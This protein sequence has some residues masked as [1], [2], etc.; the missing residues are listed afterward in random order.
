[1]RHDL[2]AKYY[3]HYY[4]TTKMFEK[5]QHILSINI[6]KV[7]QYFHQLYWASSDRNICAVLSTLSGHYTNSAWLASLIC[8]SKLQGLYL[9]RTPAKP[10]RYYHFFNAISVF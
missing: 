5:D 9:P 4:S 8:T 2:I 10:Q 1:M 6:W 3:A 7:W